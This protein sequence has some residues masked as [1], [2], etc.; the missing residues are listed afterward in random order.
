MAGKISCLVFLLSIICTGYSMAQA[1]D[2]YTLENGMRI[3]VD[4]DNRFP[5][6]SMRLYVRAGSSLEKPGQEG[7]SHFLEHMAFK[8]SDTRK[9]GEVARQVEQAGGSINAGTSF[10]YTVYTL[11]LPADRLHLGLDI[12]QDM[13]LEAS[14]PRD[15]FDMEKKVV[16]AEIHR[17][18][19]N[20]GSR[21]FSSL[22][23]RIWHGTP[24][25]HPILGHAETVQDMTPGDMRKYQQRHYQPRSMVLAVSGDVDPADVL[26]TT[27]QIFGP[28]ENRGTLQALPNLEIDSCRQNPVQVMH[29]PWQKAYLAVGLPVPEIG[30]PWNT[31]LDV[32]A[33]LLGGDTTSLLYRKFKYE[34]ALV[35]DISASSMSL[36]R[37]G[38]LYFYVRLDPDNLEPFWEKFTRTL[39]GLDIS[40]FTDQD[41]ERA[42]ISMEERIYRSR[43]TLSGKASGLGFDLLMKNDAM[44]TD[45]SLQELQTITRKDLQSAMEKFLDL[46]GAFA[47]ML[48]PEQAPAGEDAFS[49]R[50]QLTEAQ[51]EREAARESRQPSQ[52]VIRDLGQGRKLVVMPDEHLPYSA[53]RITWPGSDMLIPCEQQG[54]PQLSAS[55]LT[56]QT[57]DRSFSE[58]QNFLKNRG[59]SLGAFAG[60]Q[61]VSISARFPT[62][63][64]REVFELIQ[65]VVTRPAFSPEELQRAVDDQ[66]A[67]IREQEDQPLGYAFRHL[68]PFIFESG[69]YG[70]LHLGKKDYLQQVTPEDVRTFWEMQIQTPFVIAISGQVNMQELDG[71]VRNL[72]DIRPAGAPSPQ[73]PQWGQEKQRQARLKDRTQAH[74]LR[75]YPVVGK[76]HQDTPGLKVLNRVLSGQGGM[77]FREL[78]DRQGLAYSVTSMLWQTPEAGFIALYIGTFADRTREALEGFEYVVDELKKTPLDEAGVER[79]ANMLF[80][81][82]HRGRQTLSSRSREAS[83]LLAQ[84][85]DLNFRKELIKLAKQVSPE[86]VQEL[87]CKYLDLEKSYLF[88]IIPD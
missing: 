77:L 41:L 65:E 45:K 17:S 7:M 74:L 1:H 4:Q 76:T 60:R 56:R 55:A 52:P 2:I 54:L 32:L 34:A 71:F 28:A 63:Y 27:R 31:A 21:V 9:A 59:A 10:D 57:R 50:D 86:D 12:L 39:A 13:V 51:P 87:A 19:D 11:D 14:L 81:E 48:L 38:I 68:F 35:D 67:S 33:H 78:R 64:S 40:A 84:G 49:L 66:L 83:S 73:A 69:E 46:D 20:P 22:Q 85:L 23:S 43:E 79:A 18:M 37:V 70:R 29:G 72:Q 5:L 24:Y 16:L 25:A 8:G 88:E 58:I 26:D 15:E 80:G 53:L 82:Y 47:S 44:A 36:D 75:I 30:S 6:V 42:R 61:S 62:R 3:V